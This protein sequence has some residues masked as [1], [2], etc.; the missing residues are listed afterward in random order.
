MKFL[1]LSFVLIILTSCGTNNGIQVVECIVTD[2]EEVE[3]S[4]LEGNRK[5]YQYMTDCDYM[6]P[7]N[8][9]KY[10]IGDTITF[11]YIKPK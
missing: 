7:S 5:V 10:K 9:K 11:N 8:S 4:T 6:I 3:L 2:V 1:F